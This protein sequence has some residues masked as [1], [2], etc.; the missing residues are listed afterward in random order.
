MARLSLYLVGIYGLLA[1]FVVYSNRKNSPPRIPVSHLA[2][3]LKDA[4]ADHHTRA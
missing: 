3:Q 4:W 1:A 2:N